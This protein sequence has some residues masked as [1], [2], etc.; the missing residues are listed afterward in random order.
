MANVFTHI[1]TKSA[2]QISFRT[3]SL[4]SHSRPFR[5]HFTSPLHMALTHGDVC[6]SGGRCRR[7]KSR[8]FFARHSTWPAALVHCRSPVTTWG[9]QATTVKAARPTV[10]WTPLNWTVVKSGRSGIKDFLTA[11]TQSSISHSTENVTQNSSSHIAVTLCTGGRSTFALSVWIGY[12]VN[13]SQSRFVLGLCVRFQ[14]NA[15]RSVR[16]LS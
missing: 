1:Y 10:F 4:C 7:I 9:F 13:Y 11:T 2:L 8:L 3:A 5:S 16:I 14:S 15:L 12:F 6:P